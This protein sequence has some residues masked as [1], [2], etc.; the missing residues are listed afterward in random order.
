MELNVFPANPNEGDTVQ[1]SSIYYIYTSGV[2]DVVTN[3]I[4]YA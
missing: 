3:K 2:L 1:V 4:S